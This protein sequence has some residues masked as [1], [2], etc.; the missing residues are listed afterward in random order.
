MAAPDAYLP[1]HCQATAKLSERCVSDFDDLCSTRASMLGS[2]SEKILQVGRKR[3]T[4]GRSCS[5]PGIRGLFPL[6]PR[7]TAQHFSTPRKVV[8]KNENKRAQPSFVLLFIAAIYCH[9]SVNVARGH[10]FSKGWIGSE[11]TKKRKATL[12]RYL[13]D[14]IQ[15]RHSRQIVQQLVRASYMSHLISN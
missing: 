15:T 2:F 7:F 4:I 11:Y 8:T 14:T 12:R 10:V 1:L 5:S 3:R 6:N 9:P 13:N